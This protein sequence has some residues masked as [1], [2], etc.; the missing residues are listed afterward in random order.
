MLKRVCGRALSRARVCA[1]VC[2]CACMREKEKEK[3]KKNVCAGVFTCVCL[4]VLYVRTCMLD[5]STSAHVCSD[6]V[7]MRVKDCL[8][9][10][11]MCMCVWLYVCT[12]VCVRAGI[13]VCVNM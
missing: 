8:N 2:V 12:F 13:D 7:N 1:C 11:T 5:C 9:W 6:F 10:L 4:H 3:E